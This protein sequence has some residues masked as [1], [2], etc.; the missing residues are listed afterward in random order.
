MV[1]LG[2]QYGP[3]PNPYCLLGSATQGPNAFVQRNH[4]EATNFPTQLPSIYGPKLSIQG[5]IPAHLVE[6]KEGVRLLERR[7]VGRGVEHGVRIHEESHHP[8]DPGEDEQDW[9][10]KEE[11]GAVES[12]LQ[13]ILPTRG[14]QGRIQ[15]VIDAGAAALRQ[16]EHGL[17]VRIVS[18]A[19]DT[20]PGE[21][22]RGGRQLES[23]SIM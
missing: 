4:T 22:L 20:G 19:A 15:G 10:P 6:L 17:E 1:D 3:T 9:D 11:P 13:Q 8:S 7:A 5:T 12:F 21:G 16:R 23:N 2:L 18:A 14:P